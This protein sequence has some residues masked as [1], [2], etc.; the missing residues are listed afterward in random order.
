MGTVGAATS[1]LL[2]PAVRDLRLAHPQATVDMVTTLQADIHDG[3]LEGV[4]DIG[5]VNLLEN[6]PDIG[7]VPADLSPT[8]L[9]QGRPVAVLPMG[10]PLADA[11]E[12]TVDALRGEPFVAMR[13][14]YL[15]HRFAHRLFDGEVPAISYSTEGAELGKIMVAEGLGL[16]VLPDYSVLGNPLV[17]GDLITTRPL[18]GDRTTVSLVAVTR[19]GQRQP[20][21]VRDLHAALVRHAA[22][23]RS[24]HG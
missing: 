10:H 24:R 19:R 11:A 1:T 7:Q 22:A 18:A 2:V 5:L 14:G 12:V 9:V 3:L 23:Y 4:L 8:V 13:S 20:E 15:M 6:D 17:R 21:A 16:T